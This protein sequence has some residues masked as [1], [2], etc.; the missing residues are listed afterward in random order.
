M[1]KLALV[2]CLLMHSFVLVAQQQVKETTIAEFDAAL[3]RLVAQEAQWH[4]VIDAVNIEQ[5]PVDY[6]IGKTICGE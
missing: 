3:Q 5:V 4:K 6:A 2:I 1:Q